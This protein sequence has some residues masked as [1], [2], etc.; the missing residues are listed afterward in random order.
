MA[1]AT[2]NNSGGYDYNFVDTPHDRY[3]YNI[4]HLPSR[5]PY[6]SECC[7][8][9]FCKSCL[10]NV[11]KAEAITNA[12]PV[13]RDEKF[14]TFSNKQLDREIKSLFTYTVLTR[15]KVVSGRVN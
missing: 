11:K 5:D 12:C 7:G 14:V 4:C 8:H 13:C 9:V 1:I 15:R 6:L 2:P 3:I 10:D